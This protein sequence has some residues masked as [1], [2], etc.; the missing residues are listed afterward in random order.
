VSNPASPEEL[1]R[2]RAQLTKEIA[3]LD[4]QIAALEKPAAEKIPASGPEQSGSLLP[5]EFLRHYAPPPE[6]PAV[7][8]R[9]CFFAF[10]AALLSLAAFVTAA[11]FLFYRQPG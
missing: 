3:A 1:R 9:G 10:A 4:R 2:R 6:N 5:D 8:R 7:L 11:Y